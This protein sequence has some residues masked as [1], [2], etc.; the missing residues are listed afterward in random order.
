M[1]TEQLLIIAVVL[2]NLLWII[3]LRIAITKV[4]VPMRLTIQSISADRDGW[5]NVAQR[6]LVI[7]QLS[8]RVTRRA[9]SLA[10]RLTKS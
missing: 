6:A 9:T 10:T 2:T 4:Y 1:S 5:R 7:A 3:A 8:K